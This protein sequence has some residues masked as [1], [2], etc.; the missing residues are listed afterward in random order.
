MP[1]NINLEQGEEGEWFQFFESDVDFETEKV[2]YHPPT[3]EGRV[4]VRSSTPFFQAQAAKRKRQGE[5]AYNP[6]TRQMEKIVSVV[7]QTPEER[8]AEREDLWDYCIT[9]IENFKDSKSGKAI[10]CTRENKLKLMKIP[11]FDRFVARCWELL[12]NSK[13]VEDDKLEKN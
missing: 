9:G 4:K 2:I 5:F 12:T 8:M 13:A 1:V 11:V 6:K 10:N 7:E 3:T